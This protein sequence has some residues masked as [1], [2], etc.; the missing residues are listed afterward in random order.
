VVRNDTADQL[1]NPQR[2]AWITAA[3]GLVPTATGIVVGTALVL[4]GGRVVNSL[5]FETSLRDPVVLGGM[6]AVLLAT[7]AL[8]SLVPGLR[9]ARTNPMEA[10]RA[11]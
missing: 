1:D 3:H 9:A 5:L 2:V 6:I 10:L 7:A 4:A 11:E 8:A